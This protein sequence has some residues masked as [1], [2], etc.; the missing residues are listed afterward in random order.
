[1][2]TDGTLRDDTDIGWELDLVNELQIYKNLKWEIAGG[3]LFA[4]DAMDFKRT[5]VNTNKPMD[6]PWAILTRLTYN[7]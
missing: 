5:G 7:F 3:V 4:G 1:V 6:N 2:K